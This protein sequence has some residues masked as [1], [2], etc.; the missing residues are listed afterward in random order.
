ME[1]WSQD[2]ALVH[3]GS[4]ELCSVIML[5]QLGFLGNCKVC[6]TAEDF[7]SMH[8]AC[9]MRNMIK[10]VV[11]RRGLTRTDAVNEGGELDQLEVGGLVYATSKKFMSW[12]LKAWDEMDGDYP[13]SHCDCTAP[14]AEGQTLFVMLES[15]ACSNEAAGQQ[16]QHS[17]KAA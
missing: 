2:K 6:F 14:T 4:L 9:I 8:T 3:A 16:T 7:N 12:F 10:Q 11:Q 15:S 1:F 5:M 13:P 17:M